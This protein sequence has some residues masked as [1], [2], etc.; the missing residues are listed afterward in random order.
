MLEDYRLFYMPNEL[1]GSMRS[2]TNSVESIDEMQLHCTLM[3]CQD[4]ADAELE[5]NGFVLVPY[6]HAAREMYVPCRILWLE[7]GVATLN[8]EWCLEDRIFD[9][10]NNDYV[11]SDI[12]KFLNSNKFIDRLSP[13]LLNLCIES[14]IWWKNFEIKDKFWLLSHE[15]V[16]FKKVSWLSNNTKPRLFSKTF[17]SDDS[18]RKLYIDESGKVGGSAY[19]WWL[20]SAYSSN[21]YSVGYVYTTGRVYYNYS[22]NSYGCSPAFQI[23]ISRIAAQ[24]PMTDGRTT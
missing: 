9:K 24:R 2:L 15:E 22:S 11:K 16:G 20:R 6:Q 13:K 18:R 7:D 1:L 23:Q 12:R 19:Y 3:G 14:N 4:L 5:V 17:A 10:D 8:F 21:G